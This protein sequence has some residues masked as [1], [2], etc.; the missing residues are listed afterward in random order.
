MTDRF[1][2]SFM[3]Q[4]WEDLL[5]MHWPVD[6]ID[7]GQSIPDDLEIDT[8]DGQ[9]WLSVVGFRLSGLRINPV[10]WIPWPSFWEIN[11]RTYVKDKQG[12]KGV[13]FYSLDSSDISAVLGARL[14]YGLPYN[15]SLTE[16]RVSSKRITFRS[17]RKLPHAR[18]RSKFG[19]SFAPIQSD[20]EFSNSTLDHFLLERY[21]FWS[22]RKW[23]TVSTSARVRHTPYQAVRA[24]DIHYK[25]ELFSSQGIAEPTH[26]ATL[27]HYCKGLKVYA[28]APSWAFSIAGQANHK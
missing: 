16:G 13:W 24:R 25:G 17:R 22:R 2:Q 20:I 8:F 19:A 26:E 3:L 10:S 11:L 15:L 6:K 27:G 9:A 18:A 23:G 7:L 5:L 4:N 14:M 21:R 1:L 12:K 28:S